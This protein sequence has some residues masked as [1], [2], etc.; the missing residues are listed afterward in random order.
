MA[1]KNT[2]FTVTKL[3]RQPSDLRYV[4]SARLF[5]IVPSAPPDE[6]GWLA[7]LKD[8]KHSDSTRRLLHDHSAPPRFLP[9]AAGSRLYT[10]FATG[11]GRRE[12]LI[13]LF[14]AAKR[15]CEFGWYSHLTNELN[16]RL[17]LNQAFTNPRQTTTDVVAVGAASALIAV[18]VLATDF[19]C[20]ERTPFASS[21]NCRAPSSQPQIIGNTSTYGPTR[22]AF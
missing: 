19:S 17:S 18:S 15:A 6:P 8:T 22:Y 16:T 5:K 2:D 11:K 3:A 14:D 12:T 1:Y 9:P 20:S 10:Q 21:P 13:R 7:I 4:H